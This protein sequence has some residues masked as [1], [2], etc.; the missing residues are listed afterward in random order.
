M[1]YN[2]YQ[3]S[4]D[5]GRPLYRTNFKNKIMLIFLQLDDSEY[6]AAAATKAK[7]TMELEIQDLQQQ[8]DDIFRAKT[9]ARLNFIGTL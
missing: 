4:S 5:L 7:K 3:V 2:V 1:E 9:E 8:L 6:T